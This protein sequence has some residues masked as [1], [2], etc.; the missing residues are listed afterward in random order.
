MMRRPWFVPAVCATC[1]GLAGADA[2]VF[3]DHPVIVLVVFATLMTIMIGTYL[4]ATRRP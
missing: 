2:I 3:A 1:T 4:L